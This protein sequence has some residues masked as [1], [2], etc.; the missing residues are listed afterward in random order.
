MII[1]AVIQTRSESQ[2]LEPYWEM[3]TAYATSCVALTAPF[4]AGL[5]AW[6][7]NRMKRSGLEQLAP[8]RHRF[9]IAAWSIA[10]VI[11][12][13]AVTQLITLAV[14]WPSMAGVPG[15]PD[16]RM[17]GVA[18]AVTLAFIVLGLGVGRFMP[19]M[20]SVPI[21]LVVI[22]LWE[23]YPRAIEPLWI[24][25]LNGNY[26]VECC[27]LDEVPAPAA[28]SAPAI[29]A[30]G[31]FGC[32]LILCLGRVDTRPWARAAAAATSL[33]AGF[34]LAVPLVNEMGAESVVARTTG[35]SCDRSASL[36]I[37]AWRENSGRLNTVREVLTP[38][39]DAMAGLGLP[40]PVR[41]T[42]R[43][44]DETN[45]WRFIVPREND[46]SSMIYSLLYGLIPG[47]PP[48]CAANGPW[49]GENAAD[50][51]RAWLSAKAG[52]PK[53]EVRRRVSP[54][55]V[56]KAQQVLRQPLPK[57]LTWFRASR[58]VLTSCAPIADV[59]P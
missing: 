30:A 41:I 16:W 57:Q 7:A 48:P 34:A 49:P 31:I 27:S 50:P 53:A 5:A 32:G 54:E 23:V 17:I 2:F 25:H 43:E 42:E 18:S 19:P 20:L 37:C 4:C 10:P 44:V 52:L 38:V 58:N 33:I 3:A 14:V 55:A 40:K 8:A 46:K 9:V 21:L 26:F 35:L 24:R 22:L 12:A 45:E 59:A 56:E 15:G 1:L 6:E 47:E 51:I 39:V 36:E 13:A 11:M 29:V 28:L